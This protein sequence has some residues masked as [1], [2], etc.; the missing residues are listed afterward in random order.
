MSSQKGISSEDIQ[1]QYGKT[2]LENLIGN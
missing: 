2:G 1:S